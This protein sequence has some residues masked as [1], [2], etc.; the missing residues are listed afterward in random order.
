M[1][2]ARRQQKVCGAERTVF[3]RHTAQPAQFNRA[4]LGPKGLLIGYYT[5][6]SQQC[7][8]D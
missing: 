3:F 1:D 8:S 5:N 6:P 4:W 2:Y 7:K